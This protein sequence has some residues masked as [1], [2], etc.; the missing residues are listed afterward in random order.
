MIFEKKDKGK[1]NNLK[2]LC[3]ICHQRPAVTTM[4]GHV[5][6]VKVCRECKRNVRI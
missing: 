6:M 2:P 5:G 4:Q 1:I 3:Q